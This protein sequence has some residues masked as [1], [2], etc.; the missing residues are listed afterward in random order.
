MPPKKGGVRVVAD[1]PSWA[2]QIMVIPTFR[3]YGHA[4]ACTVCDEFHETKHY[5]LRLD[6]QAAV[7]VTAAIVAQLEVIGL[8]RLGLHIDS[9]VSKPPPLVVSS[10]MPPDP[11]QVQ[12]L[13]DALE[14]IAPPG[15]TVTVT[16]GKAKKPKKDKG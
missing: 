3:R 13:R 9:Q 5:H 12:I 14:G 2:N 11:R 10:R 7:I 8:G 4:R 6:D 16:N 1:D 15:S